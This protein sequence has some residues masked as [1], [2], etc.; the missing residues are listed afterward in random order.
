MERPSATC[1]DRDGEIQAT[2]SGRGIDSCRYAARSAAGRGQTCRRA[3]VVAATAAAAAAADADAD[4]SA[5]PAAPTSP[6][7]RRPCRRTALLLAACVAVALLP[8]AAR[9]QAG[10]P[11]SYSNVQQAPLFGG[12]RGAACAYS[13]GQPCGDRGSWW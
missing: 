7:R 6:G 11:V 8:T 9:A 1:S 4:A 2:R 13:W 3:A 12:L 10:C 5:P